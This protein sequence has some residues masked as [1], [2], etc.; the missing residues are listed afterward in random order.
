MKNKA[1]SLIE[2]IVALAIIV[3]LSGIVGLKLKEH[4]AKAKDTRAVAS[5]NNIRTAIQIYQI[6][7]TE[8]LYTGEISEEYSKEKV[9]ESLKKLENYLDNNSKSIIN[10][11]EFVIGGSQNTA[12]KKIKYGGKVRITFKNPDANGMSDG[13]S[14]WL[15]PVG[16]TF[17]LDTRGNKWIEY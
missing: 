10:D 5:L 4:S 16:E 9:I 14:I 2:I 13:Y 1:F 11:P 6:E 12:D 8:T 3:S 15:E 17:E 7:S